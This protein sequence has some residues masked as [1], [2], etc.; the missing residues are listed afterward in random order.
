MVTRVRKKSWLLLDQNP[1]APG[2]PRFSVWPPQAGVWP[3]RTSAG[4]PEH[5]HSGLA[6]SPVRLLVWR[7]EVSK[8]GVWIKS[9]DVWGSGLRPR[10]F[11]SHCFTIAYIFSSH[12]SCGTLAAGQTS[13]DCK[14]CSEKTLSSKMVEFKRSKRRRIQSLSLSGRTG[15]NSNI[16]TK[17]CCFLWNPKSWRDTNGRI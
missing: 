2:S 9:S 16:S 5:T 7:R 4:Y 14:Y 3:L 13:T 8:W 12:T 10:L 1:E 6:T 11:E 17:M 15:Q